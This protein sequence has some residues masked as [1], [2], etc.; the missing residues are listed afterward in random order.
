[1]SLE[2]TLRSRLTEALKA[3]DLRTA[4]V[5]RMI[6]TRITERRT[7][8]DFTGQV[9]DALVRDVVA[10]YKKSLEKAR[11]EFVAAGEKGKEHVAELEFEIA[12]C[13]GFLPAQL[14]RD[15]VAVAVQA[16]I[17]ELG[18]RDP[19]MVG[20]VVGAVMKKHKG[21][22]DAALVKEVAES[23]LAGG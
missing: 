11:T 16:A 1:M 22:V 2:A 9:D 14:G 20:R 4:N 5:I 15:A 8:A 13:Q 21:E 10:A 19:K 12:F 23:L 17:A 7:A 18:A 3:R 6:N